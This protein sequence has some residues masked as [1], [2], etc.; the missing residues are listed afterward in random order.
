M[1]DHPARDTTGH[2]AN[3]HPKV[4]PGS[5]SGSIG[6]EQ[7]GSGS[8]SSES[9]RH[10]YEGGRSGV[11]RSGTAEDAADKV[12]ETGRSLRDEATE[13]AESGKDQ[14]ADRLSQT[15]E[16][17]QRSAD[18]VRGEEQWLADLM[19]RGSRELDSFAGQLKN[20]D[21]AGLISSV[22]N[23]ARRQP[24]AF[25]GTSVAI[26]FALGRVARVAA[27][28]ASSGQSSSPAR[29]FDESAR[30]PSQPGFTPAGADASSSRGVHTVSGV[31]QG[32][33]DR[34][35]HLDTERRDADWITRTQPRRSMSRPP[36]QPRPRRW[37]HEHAGIALDLRCHS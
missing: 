4:T 8:R 10:S 19:D 27:G 11:D 17:V 28:Q 2:P 1:S 14:L 23:F 33:T 25:M 20:R 5:T 16:R 32:L 24:A 6:G 36:R 3:E 9:D 29:R 34:P 37:A 13:Q 22:E 7:G 18:S 12:R 21:F 31:D 15:A 26:G 30:Q 35:S